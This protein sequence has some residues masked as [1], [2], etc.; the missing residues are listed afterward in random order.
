MHFPQQTLVCFAAFVSP[1]LAAETRQIELEW[2]RAADLPNPNGLK[3]MYG[4]V[5]NDALILAGGSNFPVPRHL[6]G[7]KQFHRTVYWQPASSM[8][9]A[10]WVPAPTP[11]PEAMAEGG[12]AQTPHGV[13]VIGGAT[14]AGPTASSL[15]LGW[16]PVA[17][18]IH[19]ENLPELP[20]PRAYVA[21]TSVDNH[22]YAAGGLDAEGGIH[23]MLVLDLSPEGPKVWRKLPSWPGPRRFGASL[24]CIVVNG[25]K[26]L[27][28][29]GGKLGTKGPPRSEDYLSDA[30]LF[31]PDEN[32]WAV[33][34]T[35]PRPALIPATASLRPGLFAVF[36]G[37]DGHDIERLAEIGDAYRIPGD[38]MVFDAVTSRWHAGGDMPTGVAGATTIHMSRG[39]LVVGG[40]YSPGLRTAETHLVRLKPREGRQ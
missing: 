40:E 18:D 5:S 33:V 3:G 21:A 1:I 15:M 25:R 32:T 19:I 35:M 36:G 27:I 8:G 7:R 37:S 10:S 12:C 28:L 9:E 13:A 30:Y 38:V 26:K 34:A 22:L 29:C 23:E 6:G 14:P 2:H 17:R 24:G 4:G 39:W 16:D 11:L 20:T 31:D